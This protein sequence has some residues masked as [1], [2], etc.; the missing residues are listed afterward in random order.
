MCLTFLSLYNLQL[1]MSKSICYQRKGKQ[2]SKASNR[3]TLN[4]V[5]NMSNHSYT[6]L[7]ESAC[8]P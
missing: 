5:I 4:K 7:S 1:K 2:F 3:L 6:K 8:A